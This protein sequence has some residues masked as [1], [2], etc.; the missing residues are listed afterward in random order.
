MALPKERTAEVCRGFRQLVDAIRLRWEKGRASGRPGNKDRRV[1]QRVSG[2]EAQTQAE[3]GSLEQLI[4]R[5]G[6]LLLHRG[7]DVAVG[8][9][10]DPDA[11]VPETL[12]DDLRM[13]AFREHQR[14]VRVTQVVEPNMGES[15]LLDLPVPTGGKRV[16]VHRAPVTSIDHEPLIAPILPE[17]LTSPALIFA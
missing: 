10:R 14:R 13:H 2:L 11:R 15:R 6:S 4:E 12:R 16:R 3:L 9:E 8:I 17:R 5:S 1:R 7:K